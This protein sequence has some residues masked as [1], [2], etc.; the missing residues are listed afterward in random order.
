MIEHKTHNFTLDW[1]TFVQNL[2]NENLSWMLSSVRIC[3]SL[4]IAFVEIVSKVLDIIIII[5]N[6]EMKACTSYMTPLSS[7]HSSLFQHFLPTTPEAFKLMLLL[8]PFLHHKWNTRL[9]WNELVLL[10]L[11]SHVPQCHWI[12][13][14]G[15]WGTEKIKD[16]DKDS[17][18]PFT[19]QNILSSICFHF[20]T[21]SILERTDGCYGKW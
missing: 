9:T 8:F 5:W 18:F 21:S 3:F 1:W 19:Q 7:I 10:K 4:M 2:W 6:R 16:R 17:S 12:D 15:E 11:F 20:I 14:S 13:S